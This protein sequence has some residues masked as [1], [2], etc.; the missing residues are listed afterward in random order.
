MDD[1]CDALYFEDCADLSAG[2]LGLVFGFGGPDLSSN[3]DFS[4]AEFGNVPDDKGLT[5]DERVGIGFYVSDLQSFDGEGP[6]EYEREQ[7]YGKKD[8]PLP[9][10]RYCH[11]VNFRNACYC[12]HDDGG[13]CEP[14]SGEAEGAEGFNDE[15]ENGDGQP[16]PRSEIKGVP[17]VCIGAFRL[18]E[19]G[20][21][22][23]FACVSRRYLSLF[24]MI[25][26]WRGFG[27]L[28]LWEIG[29]PRFGVSECFV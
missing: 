5:A 29:N 12:N 8:S 2:N 11:G 13:K 15:G 10:D 27:F 9:F 19:P 22:E 3:F 21:F 7:R 16:E 20:I 14:D 4:P 6:G 23:S 1:E 18:R 26:C 25:G 24:Q 28:R 17:H